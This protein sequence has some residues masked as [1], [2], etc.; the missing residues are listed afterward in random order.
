MGN[1]G[2]DELEMWNQEALSNAEKAVQKYMVVSYAENFIESEL[3]LE[4]R[5]K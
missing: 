2:V 1:D 5:E 4:L 3:A